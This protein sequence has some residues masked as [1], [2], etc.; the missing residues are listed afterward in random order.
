MTKRLR[1]SAFGL[2]GHRTRYGNR[3]YIATGRLG[4][5][6]CLG[7][8]LLAGMSWSVR[9]S[10]EPTQPTRPGNVSARVWDATAGGGETEF[11]VIL[12]E[13]ES[14]AGG[15]DLPG[16]EARLQY[17]YD[18]LREVALRSQAP[19]RSALDA[20]GVPYRAFYIV[21]MLLVAGDRALVIRVA[22]RPDVARVVANPRVHQALPRHDPYGTTSSAPAGTE[23]GVRNINADDVWT[24]GYTGTNIVV[25]GQDTGYDWEHPAL[26]RQYR[27]YDG[28]TGT[29]DYNWHDAIHSGGG[30]CGADSAEPCDDYGHGTHTMGTIVGD[31]GGA[32]QIGVAPGARWI[33]CRNM[34]RGDGKPATYA[35]CF[36]FFL[37]PYP[38]GGEPM[39]DGVP[40]LAPH[41]INNSWTCPLIEGCDE[42]AI[43]MLQEIIERV[44][45]AGIV[46]VASAG[47]DGPG[48]STV[49]DPAAIYE[50]AF[51]V[52]AT[53]RY[54]DIA[55]NSSRGP[56]TRD[57]SGRPKPDVSAPGVD[58]RSSLPGDGYG[59][60]NGT[61]MAGP[62]VVGTVA[63]LWSA[64]PELVGEVDATE[65][66][67]ARTARPF[68]KT[69][70]CGEDE[71]GDVPNN[72]YG[73]G[74]IDALSAVQAA[75]AKVAV[76]KT[77]E[78]PAG[79]PAQRLLY[80]L[81]V[82]NMSGLTLTGVV[83]TDTLPVGTTFAWAIGDYAHDGGVITWAVPSLQPWA[84]LT[85]TLGVTVSHLPRGAL[86]V[87]A[88]YG[89]DAAELLAPVAGAPIQSVVP[90]RVALAPILRDWSP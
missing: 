55:D 79:V 11:V 39:T 41:V 25:A 30:V 58:V 83:L 57:G 65:S 1:P 2:P 23:W 10:R 63:L 36:E 82:T 51:S 73:W 19:L 17:A 31:D 6:L 14:L 38:I 81:Q 77:A 46:V 37:A 42:G 89:V 44:R 35:E 87:N 84:T 54:D 78:F 3:G 60:M 76:T 5:A 34:D 13:Q 16:R 27:G 28:V 12:A 74:I 8:L 61:S 22:D 40:S 56:V 33:G 26:I 45:A 88:V 71:P 50:A 48:C 66:V 52:G 7:V 85:V 68:T 20:A 67:I 15:A 18:T 69:P 53:D 9:A 47:N 75:T 72:I 43:Q 86:V 21:N 64:A 49:Q 70:T 32:N 62:H 59:T 24:L 29:H 90:W 80:T 4:V